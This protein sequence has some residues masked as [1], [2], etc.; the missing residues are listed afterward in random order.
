MMEGPTVGQG[1]AE[2]VLAIRNNN[3]ERAILDFEVEEI[4][5]DIDESLNAYSGN[6]KLNSV[7]DKGL[8]DNEEIMLLD[9][10]VLV[11]GSTHMDNEWRKDMGSE[12]CGE[13][14]S[15]CEFQVGWTVGEKNKV[16]RRVGRNKCGEKKRG[17]TK[18]F[19][20]SVARTQDSNAHDV[21]PKKTTWTRIPQQSKS[22]SKSDSVVTGSKRKI[23][24]Q[25]EEVEE[26]LVIVK[27]Y[28]MEEEVVPGNMIIQSLLWRLLCSPAGNN[29]SHKLELLRAWEPS[30]S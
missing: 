15:E 29:E 24:E 10:L 4:I 26:A 9:V 5:R 1:R 6:L 30:D 22:S 16:D 14:I 11:A 28:G 17:K 2:E 8:E 21:G 20:A 18:Q 23:S 7:L 25:N 27:K 13:A 12:K 3:S 19:H